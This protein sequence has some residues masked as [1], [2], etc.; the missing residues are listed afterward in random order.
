MDNN[1]ATGRVRISKGGQIKETLDFGLDV[2]IY[3]EVDENGEIIKKIPTSIGIVHYSKS[4]THIVPAR[5][6]KRNSG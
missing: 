4:R 5:P 3:V 6:K 2:G 1:Y